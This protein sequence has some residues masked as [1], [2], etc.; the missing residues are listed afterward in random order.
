M[1]EGHHRELHHIPEVKQVSHI[2]ALTSSP[3]LS[4]T[5]LMVGSRGP[6]RSQVCTSEPVCLLDIVDHQGLHGL[7]CRKVLVMFRKLGLAYVLPL[8]GRAS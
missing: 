1:I 7:P 8:A 2:G 3:D 4:S 6:R 5:I